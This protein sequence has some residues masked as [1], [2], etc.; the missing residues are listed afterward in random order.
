MT[1]NE[2][3]Q[4]TDVNL[5][6]SGSG[7]G[8]SGLGLTYRWSQ[9]CT[10]AA[11]AASHRQCRGR[12]TPAVH[13]LGLPAGESRPSTGD[14][15]FTPPTVSKV[16]PVV[17][18]LAVDDGSARTT[19]TT[20]VDV[21]PPTPADKGLRLDGG[22]R[23]VQAPAPRTATLPL[24]DPDVPLA[25]ATRSSDS[26]TPP[27]ETA[28]PA[29]RSTG[30]GA[31]LADDQVTTTTAEPPASTAEPGSM[32][33]TTEPETTTTTPSVVQQAAGLFCD[34]VKNA[35]GAKGRSFG[36]TLPG[37]IAIHLS[38][39]RLN[40]EK[41]GK[42]TTVSFAD[43]SVT[44]SSFL[45]ATGVSGTIGYEGIRL[46]SGTITGPKAWRSPAFTVT[47]GDDEGIFLA[48][49]GTKG[50]SSVSATGTVTG[51]TFSFLPLPTGWK[52][53]TTLTLSLGTE[54]NDVTVDA[55]ATAPSSDASPD[56]RAPTATIT[57]TVSS[58][59]TFSLAASAR[60]L[61]QVQGHAI[62][63]SGTVS[64]ATADGPVRATITGS[65][66]KPFDVVRGLSVSSLSVT[67]AP[68]DTSV[69]ITG[70]G[71]LALGAGSSD[72][73][74]GV[75]LSYDDPANWSLTADGSGSAT[76][77][78]LPGLT[79]TPSD[80][81]GAV[82]AKDGKY[83]FSLSVEPTAPWQAA[84]GVT[85]SGIKLAL[86]NVCNEGGGGRCPP[87]AS[88]YL[89]LGADGTFTVPV[90]G[91]IESRVEGALALPSGTF[92]VSASV[93]GDVAL[94][95]GFTLSNA[96]I[97]ITRGLPAPEGSAS[98]GGDGTAGAL[99][100]NLA[101]TATL[102]VVGKLPAVNVSW[103]SQGVSAWSLLGG[104]SLPGA[105]SGG[106]S[107]KLTDTV[108]GWSSFPTT[109]NVVNPVTKI[110][111]KVSIPKDAFTVSGAFDTPGWFKDLLKLPGD[112]VG[113]ATGQVNLSNGN[114]ALRMSLQTPGDWYLYGSK[115]SSANARLAS[116]YFNIERSSNDFSVALGGAALL[117]V[118]GSGSLSASS[119]DLEVAL[120]FSTAK[121]TIAGS[122][123]LSSSNGWSNAFGLS[124]LTVHG[125]AVQFGL[126][127]KTLTPSLG[128]GAD[129]TLPPSVRQPLGMPNGTRTKV[130]A[131]ISVSNPCFGLEVTNP[132]S[133]GTN[134]LDL[135]NKGVL[136]ARTFD[137]Q[138]APTGCTVGQF[139]YQ[140][141]LTLR[142]DGRILGL[143]VAIGARI[144]LSP[145]SAEASLRLGQI[146]VG[147]ATIDK[148][149]IELVVSPTSFSFKFD[150]GMD[151]LGA[152]VT[153]KGGITVNK[154]QQILDLNGSLTNLSL[155]G[156]VTVKQ[157]TVA[158]NITLGNKPAARF[159]VAGDID[160]MGSTVSAEIHLSLDNGELID[161]RADVKAKIVIGGTG[162]VVLD[163][164]FKLDYGRSRPLAVDASVAVSVAG[165]A[166]ANA[167]AQVRPSSFTLKGGFSVAGILSA[168]VE[169]AFYWG[170]VPKGATITASDGKKVAAKAGDFLLSAKDVTLDL[171]G[172]KATGSVSV[173]RASGNTWAALDTTVRLVGT[174]NDN[175]V[176]VTGSISGNGDFSLKGLGNLDL[177]GTK[178]AIA[179]DISR[180]SAA[181]TLT[182]SASGKLDVVGVSVSI[183]GDFAYMNGSTY[184]RLAGSASL[185]PG[186]F[187]LGNAAFTI[188]NFPKDAGLYASVDLKAGNVVSLTG[189]LTITAGSRFYLGVKADLK[190]PGFPIS[191]E[192]TFTNCTDVTCKTGRDTYLRA[193]AQVGRDG[194]SFGVTVE[195]SSS[196][197][198]RATASAPAK[199]KFSGD[200]G[201]LY[202]AV[203]AFYAKV[204]YAMA[205]TISSS[206]PYVEVK[207]E[208]SVDIYGKSVHCWLFGCAW[209]GWGHIIGISASF[210][211]NPFKACGYL[212]V[213]GSQFGG[214][215]GG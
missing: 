154:D 106:S 3:P 126:D 75:D 22:T 207:G 49:P 107:S 52:G 183:A 91:T 147:G 40:T 38:D 82:T 211:T 99:S 12:T 45:G 39:V 10:T 79:V 121:Q 78:P 101:G 53:S 81:H 109:L 137:V 117:S 195:I 148:T 172:I 33:T 118:A 209:G 127:L 73:A 55:E 194:F 34:L 88:V 35:V 163:G 149:Q 5:S 29:P 63:V 210:Q 169:G 200:T 124:G 123:D 46:T 51:D 76:W 97:E 165:Y 20:T 8:G 18:Q 47:G 110:L 135:D 30:T 162:G 188:S 108:V 143:D 193:A 48:F 133:P 64:R 129:A 144:G 202:L 83:A 146:T 159:G 170:T 44:L 13:W 92:S 142:F 115:Q 171:G 201:S 131:N 42:D 26:G 192:V 43:S 161:A 93:P 173:G 90:V 59:G 17:I 85:L 187:N 65:L 152:R 179:A 157:A 160:L 196:G 32:T 86:S 16:T 24:P 150:G 141:G 28:A 41:C 71:Q 156:V 166:I 138:I 177:L 74:V 56:S 100:V 164:T 2:Q 120:G 199:G 167:T 114:F 1:P 208:G 197:G 175:S 66:V 189:R 27:A 206:S 168:K 112:V 191:A 9:L 25:K 19:T 31:Q 67:W 98:F 94:A 50:S 198:F 134:V 128:I 84:T 186:G 204:S 80:F 132:S 68:T 96:K 111:S 54:T 145:F 102:P 140:P 89:Q 116:A 176:T 77:Q 113:R 36:T 87:G 130:V 139:I 125:L 61:V 155:G 21:V 215:I 103:S 213:W 23:P 214:C 60:R 136:T 181:N 178:V 95:A 105:G 180:K 212:R 4:L 15:T 205:L 184:F 104:Y 158:I 153:A 57:G 7:S 203:I 119:V 70:T 122:L 37:G 62:D 11:S 174:G 182:I 185:K 190:I 14:A 58:D 6:G 72:A 151:V 69:G